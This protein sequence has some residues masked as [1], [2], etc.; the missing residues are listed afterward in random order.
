MRIYRDYDRFMVYQIKQLLD[1]N[2]IPCYLKNEFIAGAIGEVSPLDGQP[3]VWLMDP[4]WEARA[5]QLIDK[6]L[7]ENV[8]RQSQA[9]WYCKQCKETNDASFDVCWQ[10]ET[11]SGNTD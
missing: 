11:P 7:A 3:E 1:A 6:H 5:Q 10:C 9:D 4:E 2:D 8:S